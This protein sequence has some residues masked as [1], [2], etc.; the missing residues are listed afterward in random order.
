MAQ[1]YIV[2]FSPTESTHIIMVISLIAFF[3]DKSYLSDSTIAI[4]QKTL[5]ITNT[6]A[7]TS[8][9]KTFTLITNIVWVQFRSL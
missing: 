5:L 1:C 6:V 9:Y 8:L 2:L 7:W 4:A 3:P